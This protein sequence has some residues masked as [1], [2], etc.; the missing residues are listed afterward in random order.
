MILFES[1]ITLL[2]QLKQV[3]EKLSE[4]DFTKK[5]EV[6]S[7][8]TL[9]Q[10]IRHTLEFFLCLMDGYNQKKIN[11]DE[12]KHDIFTESDRRLSIKLTKTIIE[13]LQSEPEDRPI[14]FIANYSLVDR[15]DICMSSSL[16]REVSYNIEHTIH[17]MALIKVGINAM[18]KRID[19]PENFGVASSTVRHKQHA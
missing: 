18:D 9:G 2:D 17:H 8:S 14:E 10:H 16:Y 1:A 7:G 13:F 6:L 5:L 19:L 15:S 12:R 3:Q 11:Y 4:E